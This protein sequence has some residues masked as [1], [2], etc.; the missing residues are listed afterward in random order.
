[1]FYMDVAKVDRDV[2]HVATVI[3][4]CCKRL[5]QRF[6]LFFSNICC[7]CVY[8]DVAYVSHI[9]CKCIFF[10]MLHIFCN[11]FFKCFYNVSYACFKYFICLQT[12]LQMFHLDVSKVD[13]VLLL[14]THL[15]AC[16]SC[17]GT[18]DRVQASRHGKRRGHKWSPRGGR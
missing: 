14:G 17:R 13:R 8:L 5:F 12:M 10:S 11:G 16:C 7:K 18:D 4:V 1:V 6:H 15:P 3:H 9:S 2:A